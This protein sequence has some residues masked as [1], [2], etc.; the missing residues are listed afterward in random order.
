VEQ[1]VHKIES[2]S[3]IGETDDMALAGILSTQLVH[4][5]FVKNFQRPRPLSAEDRVK[6]CR[7]N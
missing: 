5:L 7:L 3:A 4:Q 6:L 2:G 1:L